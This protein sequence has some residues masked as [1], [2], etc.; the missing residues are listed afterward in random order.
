MADDLKIIPAGFLSP[1]TTS[2]RAPLI[3]EIQDAAA[4]ERGPGYITYGN[5]RIAG[6]CVVVLYRLSSDNVK[7]IEADRI[8]LNGQR[9]GHRGKPVKAGDQLPMLILMCEADVVDGRVFLNGTDDLWVT[10]VSYG[11]APG[12]WLWDKN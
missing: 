11:D 10:R 2:H 6:P 5:A 1:V 7:A 9:S 8:S 4:L 12:W 3:A